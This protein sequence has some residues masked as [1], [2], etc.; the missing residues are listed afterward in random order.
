MNEKT[1]MEE[2]KKKIIKEFSFDAEKAFVAM[3]IAMEAYRKGFDY[4]V[5][6]SQ[7]Q[8]RE[9]IDKI[10]KEA[11]DDRSQNDAQL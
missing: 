10:K 6:V 9:Q 1:H 2:I 8:L 7:A 4:G 5:A 3:E 11:E